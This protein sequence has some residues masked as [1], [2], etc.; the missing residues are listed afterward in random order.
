MIA[1]PINERF[2]RNSSGFNCAERGSITAITPSVARTS[3]VNRSAVI[4]S[5]S[6]NA[7]KSSTN[8]GVAE[9]NS[10]PF[11]AVESLVEVV[12]ALR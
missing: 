5:L 9:V 7:A 11:A 4:L 3:D 6:T 1:A 8:E 10:E 12:G 2:P